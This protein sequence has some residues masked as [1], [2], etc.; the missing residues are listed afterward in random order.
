M[1]Y[2]LFRPVHRRLAADPRLEFDFAGR[3]GSSRKPEKMYRAAG[4]EG[5]RV[6]HT[7]R[8]KLARYDMFIACNFRTRPWRARWKVQT[9]HGVSPVN[10]F[11]KKP[12]RILKY[13]RLFLYGPHMKRRLI[14]TG[15]LPEDDP[16]MMVIG[17]PKLDALV[18]GSLDRERIL[19]ECGL[20]PARRTVLY[21][22]G[23]KKKGS[24]PAAGDQIVRALSEMD[25][26][27]L[28]KLHDRSRDPEWSGCDWGARLAAL[29]LPRLHLAE[30]FDVVPYMFAADLMITDVSSVSYEFCVLDRPIVI[31]ETP[32]AMD[33]YPERGQAVWNQ[34]HGEVVTARAEVIPAVERAFAD[35]AARGEIRRWKAE[36][37][38]Y[39]PGTATDRA[40]AAIYEMLG[41]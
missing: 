28:V 41:L 24:L 37:L 18:D 17:W 4:L 3:D 31:F 19:T 7:A 16:R 21:A 34:D 9:Y 38:Y 1:N 20:D 30:G 15:T 2:S 14:E 8:L 22:P 13:D 23:W 36:Q 40:V 25:C 11:L 39:K 29:E 32:G 35:P 6:V 33:H 10:S 5:G 12:R 26:N 27:V